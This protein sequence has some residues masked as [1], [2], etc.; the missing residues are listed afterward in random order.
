MNGREFLIAIIEKSEIK[1]RTESILAPG[2]PNPIKASKFYIS[3]L[4][5][6]ISIKYCDRGL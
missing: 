2:I 6:R 5:S 1:D 4:I 3:D